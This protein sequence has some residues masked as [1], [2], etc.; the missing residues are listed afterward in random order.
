MTQ[1]EP[2]APRRPGA[3]NWRIVGWSIP[4][5]LLSIPFIAMQYTREVNWDETDF[6]VMGA[7]MLFV[8]LA[9]E[10]AAR[11]ATMP[12]ARASSR[13]SPNMAIASLLPWSGS[14]PRSRHAIWR[15]R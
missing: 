2:T 9:L 14:R 7:M 1:A 3:I 6:I 11:L 13:R 5:I 10:G 15:A 4:V 8:G 12:E